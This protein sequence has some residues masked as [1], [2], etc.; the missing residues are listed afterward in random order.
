MRKL[1]KTRRVL[2]IDIGG[3]SVKLMLSGRRKVRTLDTG[4]SLRP[5]EI[6]ETVLQST[7]DWSFDVVSIGYP[8]LVSG[9]RPAGRRD[10]IGR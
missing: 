9:G 4:D 1:N 2:M 7:R 5:Q 8:G 6:V 3:D 10:V